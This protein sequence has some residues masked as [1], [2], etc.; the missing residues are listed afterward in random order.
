MEILDDA[1]I[2]SEGLETLKGEVAVTLTIQRKN[3]RGLGDIEVEEAASLF[4]SALT[5]HY[6]DLLII[7]QRKKHG[8]LGF[9][10]RETKL[11]EFIERQA[12]NLAGLETLE[13]LNGRGCPY[14]VLL[15]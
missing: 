3:L 8:I 2:T 6:S 15:S 14:F 10:H 7:V 11:K 5:I 4:L 1:C 9:M 12:K 13:T